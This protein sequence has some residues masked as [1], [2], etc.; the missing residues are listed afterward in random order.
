M[1][2]CT[3]NQVLDTIASAYK[4]SSVQIR[5]YIFSGNVYPYLNKD[6]KIGETYQSSLYEL[7]GSALE[8]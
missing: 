6:V 7:V 8:A 1:I 5:V 4:L 3:G 2:G